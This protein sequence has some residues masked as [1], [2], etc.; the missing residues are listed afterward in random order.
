MLI[1]VPEGSGS[2]YGFG[3]KVTAVKKNCS[4][5]DNAGTE[6]SIFPLGIIDTFSLIRYTSNRLITNM[7]NLR[8]PAKQCQLEGPSTTTNNQIFSNT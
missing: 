8:I 3:Y 1:P 7:L 2:S 6:I 4:T 5:T